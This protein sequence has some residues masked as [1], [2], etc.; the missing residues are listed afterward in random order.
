MKDFAPQFT[1]LVTQLADLVVERLGGKVLACQ[2]RILCAEENLLKESKPVSRRK[3]HGAWKVDGWL[4]DP[5]ATDSW[6]RLVHCAAG[7]AGRDRGTVVETS[8]FTGLSGTVFAGAL[9]LGRA[10][11]NA[12][13]KRLQDS[14]MRWI[15][16]FAGDAV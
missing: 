12:G 3:I 5:A 8:C 14:G 15:E 16:V 6:V 9:I 2:R 13:I 4:G 1:Q 7:L 10:Q 11:K